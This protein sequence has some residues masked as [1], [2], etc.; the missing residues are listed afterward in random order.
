MR[1]RSLKINSIVPFSTLLLRKSECDGEIE[2][3]RIP[4]SV[5]SIK[6]RQEI[7]KAFVGDKEM[8]CKTELYK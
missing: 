8:H 2:T 4:V 5:R 7:V 1:K 3:S 6:K